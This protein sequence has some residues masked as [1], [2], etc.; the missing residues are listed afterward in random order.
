MKA[1]NSLFSWIWKLLVCTIAYIV[2]TVIGGGL[3]TALSIE[4]PQAPGGG[5]PT[6]QGL[7]L[8]PAGL[9][10]ALGL[11]AMATG[12]AGRWWERWIILSLFLWGIN[13]VGNAIETTIF[14]TLGGPVGAALAFLLPAI[15][16]AYAVAHLFPGPAETSFAD[17]ASEFLSTWKP[18][19]LAVRIALGIL[20]FPL[21][22]IF[23]GMLVAP[24]VTPYYDQLDFLKIPPISVMLP[25]LHGRSALILLVTL[26]VIF[27]WAGSRKHFIFGLGLGNAT[28]VGLGGLMQVTFFPVILRWVHGVEILADGIA[29]AWLLALLFIPK[30]LADK[31]TSAVPAGEVV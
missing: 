5:D 10:F 4:M 3:V 16:C 1:N 14:T 27:G 24:I 9:I 23:F 29:Y 30:L 6:L 17:Q 13:G 18:S 22:Y 2:G 15:C 7:L 19:K 20:A 11:A 31:A 21:V 26:P 25:V 28:A 8:F 12:L